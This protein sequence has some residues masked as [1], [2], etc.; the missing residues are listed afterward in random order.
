MIVDQALWVAAIIF[1]I[2]LFGVL[3]RRNV[4]F[5]LMSLE[6]MLNAVALA[7]VAGGS[8]WGQADGQI[9]FIFILS[10]A[11]AEIAVALSLVLNLYRHFHTVD[12]DQINEMRG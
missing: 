2:G 1:C 10:F 3:L 12:I 8:R 6:L 5:I 9:M 7:F 11:A 4:L